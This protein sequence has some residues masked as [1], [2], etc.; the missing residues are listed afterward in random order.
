[1]SQS[2]PLLR[3]AV[4]AIKEKI[5]SGASTATPEELAYLGTAIDRI[6]GRA[7]VIEVE[8]VGDLQKAEITTHG[9]Q[10]RT[11]AIASITATRTTAEATITQTRTTAEASV[12]Q[13]GTTTIASVNTAS[14]AAITAANA[15]RDT[16]ISQTNT[17]RDQVIAQTNTF[18][19]QALA[20]VAAAANTVTQQFTFGASAY[21][22][23]QL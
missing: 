1:M 6:G 7:T 10:V 18:K 3:N 12:S 2:S 23:A 5:I 11:A 15:N 14:N 17:H 4:R 8:D 16:V 9:E 21:F 19:N 13:T 20:D 22:Y